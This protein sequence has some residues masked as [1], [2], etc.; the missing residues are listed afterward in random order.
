[1]STLD[2]STIRTP[3]NLLSL[4]DDFGPC[5][6]VRGELVMMNPTG[7]YH[8]GI[9]NTI[10]LQ[11]TTHVRKKGLGKVFSADTGFQLD[12]NTVRCPD[13]SF[14]HTERVPPS[15]PEGFFP[16]PPDLAVEIR[17]PH[18]KVSD[19]L[20]KIGSYLEYG[21]KIVWDV[22]PASK[23][24]AVYDATGAVKLFHEGE[25]VTEESL[26]P[27]FLITVDEIFAW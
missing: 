4:P 18:D 5:E 11:L 1:M 27:G 15:P 6:L 16:G 9:E 19:I 8:G 2:F 25:T 14:V 24:V 20:A 17:S 10:A 13:V 21:V 23:T 3:E 22:D 7:S 12:E 26:L